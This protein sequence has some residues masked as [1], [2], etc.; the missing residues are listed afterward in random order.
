MVRRKGK[1]KAWVASQTE[2]RPNEMDYEASDEDLTATGGLGPIL[3]LFL[4]SS[5]F[6]EFCQC[7]PKRVSNNSYDTESFALVLLAGF[8]V[9]FDCLD[10]LE[11]FQYNPL[12][13][14]RFGLV[15]TPKAFGD[16]LRDFD[17][18]DVKRLKEF[19]RHHAQF[20][21]SKID[22]R[23]PLT[24]DMD[25]TTHTQCATKMEG[26]DFDYKGNWGLSS[27]SCSDELGFSHAMELRSGNTF[28]SVGAPDMIREVF[29]HLKYT[30]EKLFRADSAFCNQE[31]VEEC[32][33]VGAKFTITA[34]GNIG[35]EPKA[36]LITD[37]S[38]WK[39]TQEELQMFVD[40]D[41][42]PPRIELGSFVY[43]PGW[44][45]LLRFYVV[46]KRTWKYD[47]DLKQE[48]W[49]YYGVLT[50]LDLFRNSLQNV[51]LFH[52][53]RS[54]AENVIREHKYN[55]DLKHFPC[56]KLLA[57]QVYGLFA[58]IAHNH[59]R[60]VALLDNREHPLYAKRLRFK[61][62][63]QPGR[64][65]THARRQILKLATRVIK[66]AQAM[67]TAW[68]ATREPVLARGG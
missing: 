66:E 50:N 32:V 37:W 63:F 61:Y 10:D 31:C 19:L 54:A 34:H 23:A 27:L 22:T 14:Q 13:V 25:S 41:V 9:G 29:S 64:I 57:N 3:D 51:I 4:D 38:E 5:V 15:P 8:F 28:S 46:V 40:K 49:Y 26:L 65:I 59:L 67:S 21:R 58:L 47:P 36:K 30:D 12:I 62:I 52:N 43:Q 56:R 53:K 11:L 33:R 20:S 18:A 45:D 16:W 35:W 44:S 42:A 17:E 1:L 55:F 24:V 60:T 39:W 68:T 2:Y 48:R 6:S 7:L